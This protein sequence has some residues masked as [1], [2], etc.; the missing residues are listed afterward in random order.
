MQDWKDEGRSIR[1][2]AAD[3]SHGE[4]GEQQVAHRER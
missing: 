4:H 2:E 1:K 3:Q